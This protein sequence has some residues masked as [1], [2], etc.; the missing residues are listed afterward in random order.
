MGD[1]FLDLICA[2]NYYY[3][4]V[5]CFIGRPRI[6]RQ[7]PIFEFN[8][9]GFISSELILI[10]INVIVQYGLLYCYG[11]LMGPDYKLTYLDVHQSLLQTP[12]LQP[13]STPLFS[14]RM[15]PDLFCPN[16]HCSQLRAAYATKDAK[17]NW[18]TPVISLYDQ[19]KTSSDSYRELCFTQDSLSSLHC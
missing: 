10:K 16:V 12:L 9:I 15:Y 19:F 17:Y 13:V 4:V 11:T 8:Q 2:H 1:P 18:L 7:S 3:D 14:T 6:N 5:L